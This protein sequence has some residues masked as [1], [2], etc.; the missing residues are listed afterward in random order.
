VSPAGLGGWSVERRAGSARILHGP[1]PARADLGGRVVALCSVTGP[2]AVVLGSTQA[3]GVVDRE[4]AERRGV[5]VVRRSSGGGAV[6]V[7]LDAQVWLDAWLPRDDPLFEDDVV[8]S[9]WWLG[10]T[11]A[12]ALEELG[13]APLVVHRGRATRTDWSGVLCFAGLGPG[14]VTLGTKKV[15]GIAQRRTRH[16]ARFHSMALR[17]WEPAALVELMASPVPGATRSL[18]DVAA[19][20]DDVL[21]ATRHDIGERRV[22]AAVEGALLRALP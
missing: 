12:R 11:W 7:G 10:E 15:V 4:R 1:W 3:A 14:E 18:D 17:C 19:G 13:S 16:G 22:V 5:D 6:L 20:L 2:G 9:S 21:S 8:R